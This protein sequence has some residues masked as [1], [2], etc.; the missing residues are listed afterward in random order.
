MM[1]SAFLARLRDDVRGSPIAEFAVVA[2]TMMLLIMASMDLAYSSYV[3]SVLEGEIQKASRDSGMEGSTDRLDAIEAKAEN[4]VRIIVKNATFSPLRKSYTSY[5]TAK[6]ER[7]TDTNGNGQRDAGECFDDVNAN[8]QWDSDPGN[9][10]QGGANDVAA[11]TMKMSFPRL[12]P[13]AGMIGLPSTETITVKT[14]LRN[15][16]YNAQNIPTVKNICT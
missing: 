7:F 4:Q 15:Q 1:R 6:P 11:Y 16:P 12:F 8:D 2:P 3:T 9:T 10:G 14:Y 13:L 5:L